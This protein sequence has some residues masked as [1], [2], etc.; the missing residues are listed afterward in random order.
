MDLSYVPE[1][2][3]YI[4]QVS[5]NL[6]FV[7]SHFQQTRAQ[8]FDASLD[9]DSKFNELAGFGVQETRSAIC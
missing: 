2:L 3:L 4:L 8:G 9:E 7:A 6:F 5:P 1:S